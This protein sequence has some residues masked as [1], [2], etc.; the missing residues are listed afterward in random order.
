MRCYVAKRKS[1]FAQPTTALDDAA[2]QREVEALIAPRRVV[3][4]DVPVERILPN[5]FQARQTFAGV[6]ELAAAIQQQGFVTRL[7]IRPHPEQMGM[8]QLVFGER[9][10]RA[11]TLAGLAAVPCEIADH[12]DD[13][14]IEI[15]LA[16]NIQ[17]RDLLPLEEAEAF[18]TLIDGRG[19]TIRS[20]A[21]RIGKDKS[22]VQ[23][24]LALRT[25]PADVQALVMQRPDTLRS[26]REL[27]KLATAA[28]RAPLIAGLVEG[29]LSTQDV[30]EIVRQGN[31]A[32]DGE[33]AAGPTIPR[34]RAIM[35]DPQKLGTIIT[36][37]REHAPQLTPRERTRLR[38]E[39][40]DVQASI[41]ELLRMLKG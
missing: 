38:R 25:T 7:R 22:Y 2:R 6:D 13:E 3:V 28:E 15:G 35:R 8:F 14:L 20:L 40:V 10:L 1:F 5:P 17:R 41:K 31:A 4:Q 36:R 39:L 27:G 19:Y 23:D 33:A 9:R 30:R 32:T 21:E 12:T 34:T 26:A 16:E 11:A 24:R 18:A 37:L 29:T